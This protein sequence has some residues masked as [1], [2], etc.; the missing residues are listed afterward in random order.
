[1][2]DQRTLNKIQKW[3][4]FKELDP[5]LKQELEEIIVGPGL[6]EEDS[7]SEVQNN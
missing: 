6:E 1:M 5:V 4:N 7:V 2:I 3:E